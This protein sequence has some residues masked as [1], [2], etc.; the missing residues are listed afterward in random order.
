MWNDSG[1]DTDSG[2]VVGDIAKD[3]GVGSDASVVADADRAEDLGARADE[4]EPPDG[5][6]DQAHG[7]G[8]A[9]G[10]E[11]DGDKRTDGAKWPDDSGAVYHDVT[12]VEEETGADA[13]GVSYVDSGDHHREAPAEVGKEW[14]ALSAGP[15]LEPV[16]KNGLENGRE[17]ADGNAYSGFAKVVPDDADVVPTG[18]DSDVFA[19]VF[20]HGQ[21]VGEWQATSNAR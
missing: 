11:A 7:L 13:G 14:D 5:R 10:I 4:H 16:E 9:A 21:T 19:D 1:G 15:G 2:G 8:C 3:D 6:A 17:D 20:E 12:V 18:G